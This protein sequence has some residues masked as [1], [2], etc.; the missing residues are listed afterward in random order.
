MSKL[1]KMHHESVQSFCEQKIHPVNQFLWKEEERDTGHW[2]FGDAGNA[3]ELR[4]RINE[5]WQEGADRIRSMQTET[6]SAPTSV[7]R[8]RVRSDQGDSLDIHSVYKGNLSTA[9]E[10]SRREHRRAPAVVRI[11]AVVAGACSQYPSQFFYRG[12]AVA[13]LTD[14]LTEA[15]YSVE[16]VAACVAENINDRKYRHSDNSIDYCHTI[17]LKHSTAPL[18]LSQIAAVLCQQGFVRYFMFRSFCALDNRVGTHFG[19]Y[20]N[21]DKLDRLA[22]ESVDETNVKTLTIGY[23]VDTE[24]K[25]KA[26]IEKCVAEIETEVS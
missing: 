6:A 16:V 23:E 5:G 2:R 21:P 4:R 19:W 3:L 7:K 9:W 12:A 14:L 26:W 25:A 13:K 1:W 22:V 24:I 20:G 15:G 8:H 11:V 17:T 18:D 10:K